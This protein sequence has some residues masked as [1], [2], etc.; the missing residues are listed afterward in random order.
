MTITIDDWTEK[1]VEPE[2]VARALLAAT[3][4]DVDRFIAEFF[5]LLSHKDMPIVKQ[6]SISVLKGIEQ[7]QA[8]R[9]DFHLG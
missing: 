6:H 9:K 8:T 2:Q 1:S 5:K 4:D 7:I 3:P